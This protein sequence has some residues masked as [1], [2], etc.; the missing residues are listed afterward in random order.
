MGARV[1]TGVEAGGVVGTVVASVIVVVFIMVV[2]VI[3][4]KQFNQQIAS[5]LPEF[6]N[7]GKHERIR[8]RAAV[9]YMD[10]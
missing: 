9:A 1:I 4:Q 3:A 5:I 7:N 2:V 10:T 8:S 6:L